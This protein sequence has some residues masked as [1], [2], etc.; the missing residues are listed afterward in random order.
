MANPKIK[1]SKSQKIFEV[2][3]GE[4]L[5]ASLLANDLPV[6]SS[7]SGEGVC[8]KCRIQIISGMAHLSIPNDTEKFLADT[9]E[10]ESNERISCQTE[11]LGDIEVDTRYW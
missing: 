2:P 3:R 4:N 1:V 9:N 7:C 10:L 8:G 6:A 11:V 5:M